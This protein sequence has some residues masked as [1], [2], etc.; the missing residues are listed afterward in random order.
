MK[1][2]DYKATV[3]STPSTNYS[4]NSA[5]GIVTVANATTLYNYNS[6]NVFTGVG[7]ANSNSKNI[8]LGGEYG[9]AQYDNINNIDASTS[10]GDNTLAGDSKGNQITA[11]SGADVINN[12]N[13]K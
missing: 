9:S 5:S 1:I 8:W 2:T 7:L 3:D 6:A 12:S 11:G 10:T 13:F 4:D